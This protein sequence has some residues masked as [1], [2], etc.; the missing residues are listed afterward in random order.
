LS[1]NPIP[2]EG[3]LA[4]DQVYVGEQYGGVFLQAP[5]KFSDKH[6]SAIVEQ[7]ML[8]TPIDAVF[9]NHQHRRDADYSRQANSVLIDLSLSYLNSTKGGLIIQIHGFAQEKRKS[10]AAKNANIIVS[11]GHQGATRLPSEFAQCLRDTGFEGVSVFGRDV[12]ELGATK[13]S[14]KNALYENGFHRFLHLELSL[15]QRLALRDTP[16]LRSRFSKCM[17]TLAIRPA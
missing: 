14:V 2:V 15:Q 6:T 17:T 3:D 5:H 1:F 4:P 11:S 10:K 8:L 16:D 7:M 12:D 13:N 9:I